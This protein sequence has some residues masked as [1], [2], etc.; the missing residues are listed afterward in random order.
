[1][2]TNLLQ[3]CEPIMQLSDQT[4]FACGE[5]PMEKFNIVDA[6]VENFMLGGWYY[7]A[8]ITFVLVCVLFAAWKAPAWVKALARVAIAIGIFTAL[9]GLS[10]MAEICATVGTDV[11]FSVY[12]SGFRVILIPP[13]YS[14]IVYIVATIADMV[15][16]PRI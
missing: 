7:M 14:V 8:A 1:M 3:T 11:P 4:I 2:L 16:R 12:C 10:E 15:R 9:K 5:A 13:I 6:I